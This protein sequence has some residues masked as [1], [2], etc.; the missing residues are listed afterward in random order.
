MAKHILATTTCAFTPLF[1]IFLQSESSLS[2]NGG[3][4]G[5][6]EN[7]EGKLINSQ[8]KMLAIKDVMPGWM[9]KS[10]KKARFIGH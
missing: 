4:S 1:F 9:K 2:N 10:C 7:K 3:F 5:G 6:K 8:G